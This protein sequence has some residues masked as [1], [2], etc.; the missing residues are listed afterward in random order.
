MKL[1]SILA[2]TIMGFILV[3]CSSITVKTDFDPE[4]DFATFKTY[5]WAS[6]KEM[7]PNDVLVNSPLILKRVVAAVDAELSKKGFTLVETDDADLVVLAHAG[8][9]EKTQVYQT[10][11]G[12]YRGWYDPYWG[13][14]GSQTH[15]S[16]YEEGTLV[17]D[18]ISWET[19]ELTWRGMGTQIIDDNVDT[20]KITP[21]INEWVGK[22]LSHFP[23]KNKM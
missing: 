2:V 7:N 13:P 23:P 20:E 12:Y 9:K 17:I 3:Q 21:I 11:G 4:Y 18:I 6:A 8:V 22:I 15:V 10:G 19:K 16:Q 5:R 14:Y 1:L